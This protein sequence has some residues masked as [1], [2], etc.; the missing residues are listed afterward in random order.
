MTGS[1][2]SQPSAR[3]SGS[4]GDKRGPDITTR[5]LRDRGIAADG[6]SNGSHPLPSAEPAEGRQASSALALLQLQADMRKT[7]SLSEL[8][9]FI[10][11]EARQVMRAQQIIVIERGA[12]RQSVVHTVSSL[13]SVDKSSPLV[14]WFASVVSALERSSGLEKAR[15]FEPSAFPGEYD[16]VQASYPLRHMLWVPWTAA[17]DTLVGGMLLARAT[18]WTEQD[19][20][21]CRYLASAFAHAWAAFRRPVRHSIRASL[22]S[23]RVV[24]AMCIAT[25]LGLAV[26]VPM[27]ALAPVE[28]APRQS[29]IVTPAIE[30]TVKSV[31][32]EPNAAVAEGQ[33]LLT[34]VDTVLKNR[35]EIAERE[36]LVA[37]AKHKRAAQLAFSD[38]RGRHELAIAKSELDLKLADRDYAL[39]L[40]ARTTIRAERGGVAFFADK[41]DLIGKPVAVGEKL[42]EIADPATTEF[43]IDLPVSD[44][45]VLNEGARVKV[46]L[47]SDPLTP[48][49]AKLERA[50]FKAAL[51]EG[52]QLA[53][54]LVA[55]VAGDT[56]QSMR[57]GV[58]GTAQVYSDRVPLGFYLFRR[59]IAAAR[60]WSGL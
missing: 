27:T 60:Q 24:A 8:A 36:V 43:H 23:R 14:M 16:P 26:P 18:P 42:M 32:V 35:A 29:F 51:R 47:D 20:S 4:A 40:L 50:A 10:A 17:D 2:A 28:V 34:L 38:A 53:F 49:E 15:E 52:E 57:L 33:V 11:N 55:R 39:E 46:F 13:T 25:L 21:I 58:R 1:R 45:I 6:A 44:A 7:R 48:I 12:R 30:G 5:I 41:R 9:Y 19:I 37:E 56:V 22:L 31:P 3:V 54:R 59:P